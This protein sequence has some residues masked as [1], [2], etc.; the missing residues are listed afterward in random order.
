MSAQAAYEVNKAMYGHTWFEFN[1]RTL[2][3]SVV[4]ILAAT[5]SHAK[6]VAKMMKLGPVTSVDPIDKAN[7]AAFEAMADAW[8]AEQE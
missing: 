4:P 7:Y 1:V 8:F 5:R 3:G 2:A 6:E